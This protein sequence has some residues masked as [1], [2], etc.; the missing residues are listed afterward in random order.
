MPSKLFHKNNQGFTL[1][2]VLVSILI[3]GILTAIAAPSFM[4][5]VYNKKVD[6]LVADVEGALKEAQSTAIRKSITCNVLITE[7]TVTAVKSATDSTEVPACLP[8]GSRQL[9]KLQDGSNDTLKIS[10]TGGTSGTVFTFSSRGTANITPSTEAVVIYR[11]DAA[12]NGKNKCL[13]V[14]SGI[15]IMKSGTYT[16]AVP[17]VLS[18][19]PSTTQVTTVIDSC[20]IPS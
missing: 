9:P 17:P 8:S 10:G 2:E 16:G 11:T 7:T 3:M 19:P 18:N 1:I 15:G 5:W 13:V 12:G 20:V 4:T 14:S 6:G